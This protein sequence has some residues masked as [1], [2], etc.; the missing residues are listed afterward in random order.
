MTVSTPAV[1][2]SGSEIVLR[3]KLTLSAVQAV[4]QQPDRSPAPPDVALVR[5]ERDPYIETEA[6]LRY[7]WGDR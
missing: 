4:D 1:N 5:D 7:A 6:E 2:D 3:S